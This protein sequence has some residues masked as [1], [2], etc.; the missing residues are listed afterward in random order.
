ML[1]LRVSFIPLKNCLKHPLL[2]KLTVRHQTH[3]VIKVTETAKIY[4][5]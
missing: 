2:Q 1:N 4:R 3:I 5:K